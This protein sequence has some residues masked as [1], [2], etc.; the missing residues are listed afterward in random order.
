MNAIRLLYDYLVHSQ[1]NR[2]LTRIALN[3]LFLRFQLLYIPIRPQKL[4]T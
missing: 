3:G 1:S 2:E 4:A